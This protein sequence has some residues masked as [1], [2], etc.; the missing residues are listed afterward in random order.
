M[1]AREP[2][3]ATPSSSLKLATAVVLMVVISA[4]L[5]CT[6]TAQNKTLDYQLCNQQLIPFNTDFWDNLADVVADLTHATPYAG[7]YNHRSSRPRRNKN[8]GGV[9]E[10]GSTAYGQAIC[11]SHLSKRQ[12]AGCLTFIGNRIV[13]YCNGALGADVHL[14]DCSLRYETYPF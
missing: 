11:S 8:G 6:V 2:A 10:H 3:M 13:G 1:A 14:A 4:T 5:V 12:C 7:G 9:K